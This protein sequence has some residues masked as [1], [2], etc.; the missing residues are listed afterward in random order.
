MTS[1]SKVCPCPVTFIFK[2]PCKHV[3][4]DRLDVLHHVYRLYFD[5]EVCATKLEN[6]QNVLDIGTGTGIWA[7]EG[8]CGSTFFSISYVDI[9][10]DKLTVADQF[11]AAKVVGVDLSPIQPTWSGLQRP[12]EQGFAYR[13]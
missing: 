1:E 4:A 12:Q 2:F 13:S 5:G 3:C 10:A 8:V 9:S 11:P 7:M 6:P